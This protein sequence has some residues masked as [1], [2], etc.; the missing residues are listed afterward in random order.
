MAGP[1]VSIGQTVNQIAISND[2]PIVSIANP[3]KISLDLTVL[4]TQGIQGQV[5][6]AG[7]AGPVGE[8][9]PQ[10]PQGVQ[11]SQG[12]T[13]ASGPQGAQGVQGDPGP[14]SIFVQ[15]TDPEMTG[16]GIWIQTGLGDGSGFTFWF[17]DGL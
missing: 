6:P 10:G 9:G 17:E 11:G 5:G 14:T 15:P 8:V 1:T 12:S 3:G 16:V 13:G 7:N 4:G 2:S